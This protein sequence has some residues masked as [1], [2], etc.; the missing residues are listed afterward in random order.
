MNP[1]TYERDGIRAAEL[2]KQA[3]VKRKR[4]RADVMR[5]INLVI[6]YYCAHTPIA[7]IAEKMDVSECT[8]WRMIR[9]GK[10]RWKDRTGT[11]LEGYIQDALTTVDRLEA[12]LW[13]QWEKTND[14]DCLT[15]ID[16]CVDRRCKV[17]G[18]YAPEKREHSRHVEVGATIDPTMLTSEEIQA[19]AKT[20]TGKN[21]EPAAEKEL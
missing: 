16:K 4:L 3:K 6:D 1:N 17:L 9:A 8:V 5:K 2:A 11:R 18:L 13:L 21:I 14:I 19:L 10:E 7:V 12:R 20:L 15:A